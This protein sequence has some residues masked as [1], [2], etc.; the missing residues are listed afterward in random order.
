MGYVETTEASK[1]QAAFDAVKV[2]DVF[3]SSWGYDQTNIDF[4]VVVA[5][6]KARIKV[7]SCGKK[8]VRDNGYSFSV[9][10]DTSRTFG[11]VMVKKVSASGSGAYFSVNSF[12]G[13][14]SW[15]GK[16]A[17]ETNAAYYG[18]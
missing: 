3:E 18:H 2:G 9:V 6:T 16:A 10:P 1:D 14:W 13:A 11:D 8:R 17:S 12:A 4:F 7:Q 5:K 15:D